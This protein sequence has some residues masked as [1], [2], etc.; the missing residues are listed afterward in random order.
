MSKEMFR[1]RP[2]LFA[3]EEVDQFYA[4]LFL[5][6]DDTVGDNCILHTDDICH[7]HYT[8][9]ISRLCKIAYCHLPSQDVD[10]VVKVYLGE[11]EPTDCV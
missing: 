6:I 8:A 2:V 7:H 5:M 9:L 1:G 4:D 3:C 10:E 11:P